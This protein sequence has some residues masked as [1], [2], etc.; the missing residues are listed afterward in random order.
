MAMILNTKEAN[1]TV[2][3]AN[4]VRSLMQNI[5]LAVPLPNRLEKKELVAGAKVGWEVTGMFEVVCV[6]TG[7][8]A[9]EVIVKSSSSSCW[10]VVFG[11][12]VSIWKME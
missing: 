4:M 11:E 6:T 12:K 10:F 5:P 7:W 3:K 9:K 8:V 1:A 2:D